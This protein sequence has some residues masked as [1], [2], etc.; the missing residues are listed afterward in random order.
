MPHIHG[1]LWID[2]TY[3]QKYLVPG[4]K[5]E[6]ADNIVELIDLITTC[7][8]PDDDENLAQIVTEV[9]RHRHSKSC[10]KYNNTCRFS[11]PRLPSPVTLIARPPSSD[12]SEETRTKIIDKSTKILEKAKLF[13]EQ[14]NIDETLEFEKFLENIG[15]TEEDYMTALK[16]SARG[17][18]VVLKRSVKERYIN[19]YNAEFLGAW[20][21]NMDIQFCHNVYAVCTYISDYVGRSI[22]LF[23]CRAA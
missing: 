16:T 20:N 3:L 21:A 8:I 11:Y 13:L 10:K 15:E 7:K 2:K 22:S 6:Y 19:N 23:K 14:D 1:V 18:V 4:K 9:Q 5:L 12:V 17:S